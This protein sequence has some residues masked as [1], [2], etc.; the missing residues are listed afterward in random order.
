MAGGDSFDAPHVRGGTA[1]GYALDG[2]L[3]AG[4]ALLAARTVIGLIHGALSLEPPRSVQSAGRGKETVR[5]TS[6]AGRTPIRQDLNRAAARFLLLM[7]H[8]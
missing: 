4:F 5:G 7:R 6:A 8:R 2:V 3:T 1:L